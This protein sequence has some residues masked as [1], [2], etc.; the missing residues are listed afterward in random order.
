MDRRHTLWHQ[1]V[2]RVVHITTLAIV[3]AAAAIVICCSAVHH[4]SEIGTKSE[5]R[6]PLGR[7]SGTSRGQSPEAA[8][9]ENSSFAPRIALAVSASDSEARLRSVA[10]TVDSTQSNES[11]PTSHPELEP[12][13]HLKVHPGSRSVRGDLGVVVSVEAQAT[14]AGIEILSAGGNAADAA[15][16]VAFALAVTHPSAGNLGGGGFAL[17]RP[18]GQRTRAVDFREAAPCGLDRGAFVRMIQA[19]GQG[20]A[21]VGV[22][23]TVAGLVLL[24]ETF[25]RLPL[26]RSILPAI[27][28]AERGHVVG[29]REAVAL[30]RAWPKLHLDA[31]ALRSFARRNGHPPS[32]GM[33]LR[34]PA[35]SKV[36]ERIATRGKDGFY[37]GPT[38]ESIVRALAPQSSMTLADLHS[39]HAVLRDPR[40]FLYRGLLVETMPPPSAG[41]V[42]LTQ[43]LLMLDRYRDYPDGL[44]SGQRLHLLLEIMRRAQVDRVYSVSDPDVLDASTRASNETYWLDA[45][46]WLSRAPIDPGHATDNDQLLP[47][48]TTGGLESEETTHFGVVDADGMSV[49]LT[50]T[51]SSSFGAKVVSDTGIVLNNAVASFS[52]VGKNQ[53]APCRRTVSSMAPTL[54]RDANGNMLVLGTPG[55]DA[56]PSALFQVIS[57]LVDLGLPFDQAIDAPRVHQGIWT[58]DARYESN[59]PLSQPTLRAL[60]KLGHHMAARRAA[61]GDV[62]ALFLAGGKAFAYADPREGGLAAALR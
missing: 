47:E 3:A 34:R 1:P 46:R 8:T 39:Y 4:R 25:G 10:F 56:I 14:K 38:A 16:A 15:V 59:R 33:V 18:P 26:G 23:G 22:P 55:G 31:N 27:T 6:A 50:T 37:Q 48:A 13:A 44:T 57:N 17:V 11:F 45:D 5:T 36:L 30:K 35:L 52:G 9:E 42:A 49:T 60:E 61:I 32:Q 29:P 51:L 40:Q 53:P 54:V 24:A 21:S 20:P 12:T 41:A 62:N 28:L 7:E 19:G 43:S 2:M 58:K